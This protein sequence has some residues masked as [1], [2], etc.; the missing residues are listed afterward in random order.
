MQQSGLRRDSA[1]GKPKS[2]AAAGFQRVQV[3]CCHW[4]RYT[5]HVEAR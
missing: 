2:F 5:G 4:A 1:S 3:Q